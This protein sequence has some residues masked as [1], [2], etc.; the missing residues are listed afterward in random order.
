MS[1][2]VPENVRKGIFD[3]VYL[4][5][6]AHHYL[7]KG[8]VENGVFMETLGKDPEVGGKLKN[9]LPEEDIK[10]YIKDAIL[11]R[12]AKDKTAPPRDINDRLIPIYGE[13]IFELDYVKSTQVSLHRSNSDTYIV[14]V[15]TKYIKWETGLRKLA[16]YV[17]SKPK[18]TALSESNL[19]L[20][21]IISEPQGSVNGADKNLVEKGLLLLNI[22]CLWM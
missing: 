17:A 4:K 3:Y 11:N 12:Y 14:I 21:L 13:P 1:N 2:L 10:T 16:L 6:D 18:L 5:A 15:R 20:V 9:Y 19:D 7:T 22:K 8:R